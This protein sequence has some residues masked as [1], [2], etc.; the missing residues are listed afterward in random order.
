MKNQPYGYYITVDAHHLA[1]IT[2]VLTTQ[3]YNVIGAF[4]QTSLV[5]STVGYYYCYYVGV[6]KN[7]HK[8][9]DCIVKSFTM[10]RTPRK[11]HCWSSIRCATYKYLIIRLSLSLSRSQ[12]RHPAD[13][14]KSGR[15]VQHHKTTSRIVYYCQWGVTAGHK[16]QTQVLI[17]IVRRQLHIIST[18]V[19]IRDDWKQ[20][21]RKPILAQWPW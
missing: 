6:L 8:T 1:A 19:T 7:V 5:H 20:N 18:C 2:L 3:S 11:V 13:W 9:C 16:M 12:K 21:K 17:A 14:I 10:P 4:I 15:R